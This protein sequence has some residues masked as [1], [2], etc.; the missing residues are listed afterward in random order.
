MSFGA[1]GELLQPLTQYTP[2]QGAGGGFVKTSRYSDSDAYNPD[3]VASRLDK[4][5]VAG[6]EYSP[7]DPGLL[8]A[9]EQAAKVPEPD[10]LPELERQDRKLGRTFAVRNADQVIEVPMFRPVLRE[11]PDFKSALMKDFE[12]FA[13]KAREAAKEERR[14]IVLLLMAE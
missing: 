7:F 3:R 6:R 8:D 13:Q 4:I 12:A 5:V 9:I 11:L 1:T 2:Q 10:H 14:R